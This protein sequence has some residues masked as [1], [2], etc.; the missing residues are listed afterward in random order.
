MADQ[1]PAPD[2]KAAPPEESARAI[3]DLNDK[4]FA[5]KLGIAPQAEQPKQETPEPEE[6]EAPEEP[7]AKDPPATDEVADKAE[8]EKPEE[9]PAKT[10]DFTVADKEGEFE[11]PEDLT[12][13]FKANGK[14]RTVPLEKVVQFAS[15]GVYNHEKEQKLEQREAAIT[16]A[17]QERQ[18][19]VEQLT[20]YERAIEALLTDPDKYLDA[21]QRH[22]AMNTPEARAQRQVKEAEKKAQ[23][24]QRERDA[25]IVEHSL[26]TKF[27]PRVE[28]LLADNPMVT[29]DEVMARVN[30][31]M[32]PL[33]VDGRLPVNRLEA[34][35]HLIDTELATW[36]ASKQLERD[37]TE[38]AR[39]TE[40]ARQE[41]EVRKA[42]RQLARA[43]APAGAGGAGPEKPA[44]APESA[45][46]WF[47]SVF[48]T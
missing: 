1:A 22:A 35:E 38:K 33:L 43:A 44:K 11:V 10:Y 27:I 26:E 42:K 37:E 14:T 9:K 30:M 46:D 47:K 3:L 8:E 28:R 24:A 32:V 4:D 18:A 21:Q 17:E 36:M 45:N 20:Q 12:I 34:F 7:P 29:P 48:G 41:A 39:A 5:A 31:M 23:Q 40:R 25:L 15:M 19:L 2:T 16:A 6:T 13:T